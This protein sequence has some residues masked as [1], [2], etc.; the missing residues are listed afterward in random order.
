MTNKTIGHGVQNR[1]R[2]SPGLIENGPKDMFNLSASFLFANLIWGTV[3]FGYFIYGKKQSSWV[4]MV[5]GVVMI[6]VS[7]IVGSALLMTVLSLGIIGA[8][9]Y[10]CKQGY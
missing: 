2:G 1:S 10:I 6:A 3:G 9:Y 7:Y 4:P 5:G 8:V